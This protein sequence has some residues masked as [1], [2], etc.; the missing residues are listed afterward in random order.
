M[1]PPPSPPA[2]DRAPPAGLELGADEALGRVVCVERG[3]DT[4][5]LAGADVRTP[6]AH[7]AFR[8]AQLPPPAV[9]DWVAVRT[10]EGGPAIV[11]M[12]S[13][14]GVVARRDPADR[15]TEQVVASNVEEAWL[16]FP[17]DRPLRPGRLERWLAICG[18]GDVAAVIVISKIDLDE[19]LPEIAN[20]A[21]GLAPAVPLVRL[22]LAAGTGLDVLASRLG[23]GRTVVLLG[24][25][26][27][28]KSSL[29]NALAGQDVQRVGAV[30][31]GD[32]KGRHTTVARQLV[33]VPGGGALIDTPG[34]R[35]LA[36]WSADDQLA[37][38]FPDIA[39]LGRGCRFVDCA[40]RS[41]PGCAVTEAVTAGAV[42][43]GRLERFHRLVEEAAA[44]DKRR[45]AQARAQRGRTRR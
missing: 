33:T 23:P 4:V 32:R 2:A 44:T 41:E 21:A 31:H 45:V 28:G 9:G 38:A 22:S 18:E 36:L 43:A 25:S 15:A 26:G 37:L 11:A 8:A 5:A 34:L 10:D 20:V 39:A 27:G 29:L 16:V 14:H 13:R 6:R 1:E 42:N 7:P 12:A 19:Y 40:H 24:E 35:S 3:W 17:C 30:R